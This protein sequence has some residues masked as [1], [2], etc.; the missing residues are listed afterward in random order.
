[1]TVST[2][3]ETINGRPITA[4]T[5]TKG[6]TTAV[7]NLC[8]ADPSGPCPTKVT[9][10]PVLPPRSGETPGTLAVADLPVVGKINRPWVGTDPVRARPNIAATTCDKANFVRSGAPRAATRTF[11]IPQGKL[12]EALRHHRDGRRLPR[13]AQGPC[14][15]GTASRRRWRRARRRTSAPR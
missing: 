2:V 11:L 5:A 13:P 9:V 14:L 12:A 8:D 3:M 4:R 7:R 10:A 6:L 1:M 15:R